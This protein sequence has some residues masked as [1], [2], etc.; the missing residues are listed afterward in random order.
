MQKGDRFELTYSVTT[1]VRDGFRDIFKDANPLHTDERFAREKGFD[2]EVM[3]GNILNGFISHFIGEALPVKNVIIHAQQIKFFKPFYCGDEL[4]FKA[5]IC[6]AV[7]S[8]NAFVFQFG[9]FSQSGLEIA[10]GKVQI[11]LI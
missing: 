5:E 11:G 10:R 7:V 3:Y 6:D 2:G 1:K 9:F 4:V 8:V